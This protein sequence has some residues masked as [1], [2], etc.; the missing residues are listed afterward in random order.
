MLAPAAR[1][2]RLGA[3]GLKVVFGVARNPF[4]DALSYVVFSI[5]N[6]ATVFDPVKGMYISVTAKKGTPTSRFKNVGGELS[7]QL[8]LDRA[9][10]K[11]CF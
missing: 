8:G 11:K 5:R 10:T 2:L 3:T 7:G 9:S 4:K 1:L 6:N